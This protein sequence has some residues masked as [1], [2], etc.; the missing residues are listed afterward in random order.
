MPCESNSGPN[1]P[2]MPPGE[3][4]T[5]LCSKGWQWQSAAICNTVSTPKS[6]EAVKGLLFEPFQ[7]QMTKQTFWSW[8]VCRILGLAWLAVDKRDPTLD[9][10]FLIRARNGTGCARVIGPLMIE[11]S[12]IVSFIITS[13]SHC[14]EKS[15]AHRSLALLL[16]CETSCKPSCSKM[17]ERLLL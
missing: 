17:S 5:T 8:H 3:N 6:R 1:G 9:I 2:N 15:M 11:S 12:R 10:I 4:I 16:H 13:L 14:A 7:L